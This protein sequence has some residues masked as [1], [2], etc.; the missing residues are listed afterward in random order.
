M[1]D[2][3][4]WNGHRNKA[5]YGKTNGKLAHRIA[6]QRH[7]GIDPKG[8]LVCHH[9]DNPPCVNPDHLFLGTHQDNSDDKMRKNRFKKLTGERNGAA[10]MTDDIAQM[11]INEPGTY[12]DVAKKFGVSM[13]SVR[14]AKLGIKWKHLD[15]SSAE[16]SKVIAKLTPEQ[17]TA[18]RQ[19]PRGARAAAK[20]YGVTGR[21]IVK[22]R[23]RITFKY[24]P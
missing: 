5:G 18:I 8:L 19:D 20:D 6:F 9:C 13:S 16:T 15:H 12:V 14:N 23:K 17:A 10:K 1:T 7:T 3:I 2:C 4:E 21:A 24:C 11:V 22:I